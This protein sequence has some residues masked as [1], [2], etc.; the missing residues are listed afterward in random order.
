MLKKIV[1]FAIVLVFVAGAVFWGVSQYRKDS[2]QNTAQAVGGYP[3]QIGLT[4][5]TI[6]PC[7][8]SGIP[9][10]CLGGPL[11]LTLDPGRCT[12]YAEASGMPAGGDGMRALFRKTALGQAGIT[13][14]GQLIAGGMSMTMMDNGILAGP[15]GCVGCTAQ[16]KEQESWFDKYI[17]ALFKDKEKAADHTRIEVEELDI[18]LE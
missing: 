13:A 11:C 15:A 17:I 5:V 3:Y 7:Y 6:T 14:G 1:V 10:M 4:G 18:D 9:P 2:Q 16:A 12:V 8:T